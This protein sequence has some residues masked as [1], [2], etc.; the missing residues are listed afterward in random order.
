MRVDAHKNGRERQNTRAGEHFRFVFPLNI[1][2]FLLKQSDRKTELKWRDPAFR[3]DLL[4]FMGDWY[5]KN[6]KPRIISKRRNILLW[7]NTSGRATSSPPR[8]FR[9]FAVKRRLICSFGFKVGKNRENEKTYKLS[10]R[11]SYH[12][13]VVESSGTHC[14]LVVNAVNCI[15]VSKYDCGVF[16]RHRACIGFLNWAR[17]KFRI[18]PALN[19]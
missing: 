16:K 11:R 18:L 5:E 9:R 12:A 4:R 17:L 3:S 13:A 6:I 7:E 2:I 8:E 1:K 19:A 15:E 10:T 14:K